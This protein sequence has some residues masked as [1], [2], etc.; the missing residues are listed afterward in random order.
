MLSFKEQ[1]ILLSL[2]EKSF[3]RIEKREVTT[4]SN[5][6]NLSEKRAKEGV[7]KL[8]NVYFRNR[9]TSKRVRFEETQNEREER[10]MLHI[11]NM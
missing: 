10:P 4:T 2:N 6:I 5:I 7:E 9:K 11:V 1:E 3:E 8:K